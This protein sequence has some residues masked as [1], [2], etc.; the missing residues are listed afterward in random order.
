ME[1]VGITPTGFGRG[2]GYGRGATGERVFD[3]GNMWLRSDAD[4]V[5]SVAERAYPQPFT[6]LL[7]REIEGSADGPED[8]LEEED[9]LSAMELRDMRK[10]ETPR[11]RFGFWGSFPSL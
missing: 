2:L 3:L 7:S 9:E 11:R 10:I 1:D 5:A 8:Y 6:S 4:D